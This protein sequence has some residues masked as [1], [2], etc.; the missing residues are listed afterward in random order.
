MAINTLGSVDVPLSLFSSLDTELSPSDQPEGISPDNQDVVFTP[1]AVST[2]PAL[3]RVFTTALDN[4]QVVYE[5]SYVLPNKTVKNL[6]Y[7]TLGNM[8]VEDIQLS[9]G[10]A[11]L[12]FNSTASRASSVTCDGVEYIALSDGVHGFDIP[13]QYNGTTVRRVTQDGPGTAPT[14]TSVALPSSAMTS[15]G[16]T[17][18]RLNN[19]VTGVTA[20]PH[21]LKVGYQVQISGIP[22]S[23]SSSVVQSQ[24]SSFQVATSLWSLVSGQWRSN[25]NPGT[26][27]LSDF[28]AEGF[29]FSI[30]SSAT[31]LGITVTFGAVVQSTSTATIAQVALWEA[32]SQQGTAKSPATPITVTPTVTSY[33][34]ASDLWGATLTPAI[35]NDPSFGFAVSVALTTSRGFLDFPFTVQVHYTLSGSGTVAIIQSIV[36]DNEVAPGQALITTTQPH[37]LAPQEFVSIV[38]V[39]P[40]AVA[41]V[42]AAQWV[43]G[44]T[45]LTTAAD[46][47]LTPGS[48]IQITGVTTATATTAFSFDGTFPIV[49]VPSPNQITFIQVPITATDPDVIDATANTGSITISWPIL[50]TPTPT[51]FQVVSA[52]TPTTF[53]INFNYANATWT[54]GTV[55]FI[56]EGT[57]FVTGVPSTTIF[58][59]QQYGP[60]GATTAIGTVT[61]WGQATPG[62]HEVQVFFETDTNAFTEPS[63]PFTF[64]ANGGQYLQCTIPLG[65]PNTIA[66]IL[67]FTGAGGSYFF[68]ISVPAQVN[69]QIV[70]TSTQINDNTTTSILLDFSDATLY[71]ATGTSVPGNNLVEQVVLGPCASFFTYSSRLQAW[72]EYNKV[73]NLLNMGFDGGFFASTPTLPTGWTIVGSGAALGSGRFDGFNL[74]FTGGGELQQPFY[75]DAYGDTIALPNTLYE[76]RAY[77]TGTFT[78]T[79]TISSALT[80][81]TSTATIVV[82]GTGWQIAAFSL[83][84]PD[85]IPSD[86]IFSITGT[87][88][89]GS[90]DEI[91]LIYAQQPFTDTTCKFSYED[92]FEGFDGL[93]GLAGPQDDQTAIMNWGVIRDTLYCVTGGSLHETNDNGTTEPSGWGFRHVADNCGAWAISAIGRNVQGIGSAGKE[94]MIWSGPDGAQIFVGQQPIK[95]SQEIE[96]IWQ[97]VDQSRAALCWTE[98]D[99]VNKRCYFGFPTTGLNNLMNTVVLDYRN[100]DGEGIASNPPVH[101]SFTG[102]MISS[103]LTRKWTRW[104]VP[105]MTARLMF[106]PGMVE[107]QIC[108]GGMQFL[109]GGFQTTRANSYLL[110]AAKYTDDELGVILSYYVTYFFVSHEMEQALQVGSHRK[111]YQYIT[112]YIEGVGYFNITPLGAS[113]SNAFAATPNQA[114]QQDQPFDL[115]SGLNVET[116]RCAFKIQVFPL[117]GQTDAYF[118]LQKLVVNMR[119]APWSKVRGSNSGSY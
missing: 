81:F 10:T 113:L 42:V 11:T 95:I 102:K 80:S 83:E 77:F 110:N 89:S 107:P 5:K 3:Q 52:P 50:D 117:L 25:F 30:P 16:N 8:W 84:T 57:F 103:D 38:G 62:L 90:V 26:S 9:P 32:G 36:V 39:Q 87:A 31:I 43:A 115:E 22:D 48:I 12:L 7:T 112:A 60:N 114:L 68:Y 20:T 92:N 91:S 116:S 6:Y 108:F 35:V 55:G 69:G 1:G 86:L 47:N 17:L 109:S 37:G 41:T 96:Q 67:Q 59:Y 53:Y 79:A 13:L 111:L 105:A 65:P 14:V 76:I 72:G 46:H 28:V 73:Q 78:L 18:T 97:T 4:G 58:Q 101:I 19:T 51:Y 33:G 119:I 71:S 34:G 100:L 49:S 82:H 66:R 85:S 64:I 74:T 27:A 98:N 106:R 2:R 23:N 40:S 15:S 61:P 75:E 118:S 54:S 63:P 29:G 44:V 56:W 88:G 94:W 93:T 45:T 99:Q 104:N 70:S 21:G 24:T